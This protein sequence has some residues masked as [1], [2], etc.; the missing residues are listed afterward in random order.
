[1]TRESRKIYEDLRR[2]ARLIELMVE[3]KA[4]EFEKV[5]EM[6]KMANDHGVQQVLEMV[7]EGRKVWRS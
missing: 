5:W 2:R 3:R 4:T 6:V 7:E 1:S